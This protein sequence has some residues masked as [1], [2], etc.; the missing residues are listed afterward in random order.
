MTKIFTIALSASLFFAASI[1]PSASAYLE[2][3]TIPQGGGCPQI[4]RWN[5][6]PAQ[7]LNRE[8]STSLPTIQTVF[9]AATSPPDQL[10]EIEQTITTAFNT[11][12]GVAGTTFNTL[13][14]P[15]AIGSLTRTA[16]QNTCTNDAETNIDGVNTIC[17]NQ[18]SAGFTPGVLAFTR[19]ITANAPGVSVGTSATSTFAGQILDAD[20]LFLNDATSTFATPLALATPTAAGAYD[21]QTLLTHEIGHWFGLDHS[22]IW[23]ATMFPFAPTPGQF[24]GD[25]PTGSAPDA[26]LSDDD[27][28]GIRALYPDPLDS[29]NVGAIR[30]RITP[31]NP[32]ALATLAPTSAG[33]YVTG[34]FG[35]HVVAVDAVTGEIIAGS[36]SGWSCDS[37]NPPAQFDGTFAIERLPVN[38]SYTLYAEPLSGLASPSDFATSTSESC[39]SNGTT[40]CPPPPVNSSFNGSY[41]SGT[42]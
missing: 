30:G 29:V 25:R 26:P 41:L 32:F 8:W 2:E 19:V 33:N 13:N 7:P 17:F 42:P 40:V 6:S 16:T 5:L 22:A 10:A 12:S 24:G 28:T 9:T 15:G 23:R 35:A 18:S 27:R 36:F 37:S 21:L 4:I 11:W 34:I 20:T 39:S 38:R 1:P 14:Y 3:F 31:A